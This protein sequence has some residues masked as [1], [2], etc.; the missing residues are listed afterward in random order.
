[1]A[2]DRIL[3]PHIIIVTAIIIIVVREKDRRELVVYIF[4]FRISSL[5]QLIICIKQTKTLLKFVRWVPAIKV[6][7]VTCLSR[8]CL[9]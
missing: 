6:R 8:A 2:T 5:I 4:R 1:M 7:L 3:L 9:V